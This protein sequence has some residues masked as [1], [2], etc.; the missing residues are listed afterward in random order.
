MSPSLY[1]FVSGREPVSPEEIAARFLSLPESNGD[2]RTH[3]ERLIENDPRFLWDGEALR[4]VDL[5]SLALEDVPYV[6]FDLET[7]GASA[8]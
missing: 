5:A 8:G 1:G 4:T 6:V 7:T 3:V 2:A